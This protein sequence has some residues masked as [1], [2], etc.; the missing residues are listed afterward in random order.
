MTVT[1]AI[2]KSFNEYMKEIE[3][4]NKK[5]L[6]IVISYISDY[7]VDGKFN[8]SLSNVAKIKTFLIDA[9]NITQSA[10]DLL[11]EIVSMME[12]EEMI[13]LAAVL[14]EKLASEQ[15]AILEIELQ[16]KLDAMAMKYAAEAEAIDQNSLNEIRELIKEKALSDIRQT[17]K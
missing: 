6:S 11:V 4:V 17:I 13:K 12:P 5:L 14:E 9:L 1:S 16:N 8:T 10:K 3:K 2:E 15:S 7:V